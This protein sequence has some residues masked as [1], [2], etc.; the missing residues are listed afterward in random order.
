MLSPEPLAPHETRLLRCVASEAVS[1]ELKA[2]VRYPRESIRYQPGFWETVK[3][4]WVQ[5][6]SV[7]LVVRYFTNMLTNFVRLSC[8]ASYSHS[9]VPVAALC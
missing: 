6:V 3:F 1:F 5:Y 2:K 7:L 9:T 4:A 8:T